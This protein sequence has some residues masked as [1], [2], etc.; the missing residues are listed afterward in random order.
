MIHSTF[1]KVSSTTLGL[2]SAVGQSHIGFT[3][4]SLGWSPADTDGKAEQ[5][6]HFLLHHLAS[7]ASCTCR[8]KTIFLE[9]YAKNLSGSHHH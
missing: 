4:T 9:R 7:S 2:R 1:M 5:N 6:Q 8:Q 3:T